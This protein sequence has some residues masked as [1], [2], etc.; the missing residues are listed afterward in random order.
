MCIS[1]RQGAKDLD[2]IKVDH[3]QNEIFSESVENVCRCYYCACFFFLKHS[4]LRFLPVWI[5]GILAVLNKFYLLFL[6]EVGH[7]FKTELYNVCFFV[8]ETFLL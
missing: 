2:S 6:L 4:L 8:R 7:D 5:P 1:L 3:K